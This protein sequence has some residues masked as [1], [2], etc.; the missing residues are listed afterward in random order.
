M[1]QP[2]FAK[3]KS[4]LR[5]KMTTPTCREYSQDS[6]LVRHVTLLWKLRISQTFSTSLLSPEKGRDFA[7]L[8]ASGPA[9]NEKREKLR[10]P[11]RCHRPADNFELW[12]FVVTQK[13]RPTDCFPHYY[14]HGITSS[15][16]LQTPQIFK[17][18]QK[19][20]VHRTFQHSGSSTC[21]FHPRWVHMFILDL[22]LL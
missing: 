12:N 14:N 18:S 9:H 19:Y 1:Q 5:Q 10:V 17:K 7:P 11:T 20:R 13:L 15:S 3:Q 8:R 16:N 6:K 21:H 2:H 4:R 22:V